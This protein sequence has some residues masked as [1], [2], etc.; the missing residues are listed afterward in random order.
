MH[1]QNKTFLRD[2]KINSDIH[3]S[4]AYTN[5]SY[6]MYSS[7]CEK[8]KKANKA[9]I[10]LSVLIIALLVISSIVFVLSIKN[11]F[12]ENTDT[13]DTTSLDTVKSIKAD[14]K[15]SGLMKV[16]NITDDISE[17]YNIPV[18]IKIVSINAEENNYLNGLR[19]NDIIVNI[20]GT[21]VTSI[22]DV[23]KII[24]TL[25][26]DSAMISYTVYRNGVYRDIYPF[27]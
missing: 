10:A 2:K 26:N 25:Q 27:E 17:L 9:H 23:T 15:D 11:A 5:E 16:E 7:L 4:G 24:N 19:I 22:E 3:I 6:T 1:K 20:S 21:D 13:G 8:K 12:F 14:S 18:G